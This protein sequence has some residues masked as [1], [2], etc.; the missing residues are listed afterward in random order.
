MIFLLQFEQFCINLTNKKLQQYFN[1]VC[2]WRSVPFPSLLQSPRE[3]GGGE[4]RR[5]RRRRHRWPAL[6]QPNSTSPTKTHTAWRK[7]E[8]SVD[9]TITHRRAHQC[10][11]LWWPNWLSAVKTTGLCS[12]LVRNFALLNKW[13]ASAKFQSSLCLMFCAFSS[14][15]EFSFVTCFP[16]FCLLPCKF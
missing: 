5:W 6:L 11:L 8:G 2:V 15:F 16:S 1:Q 7:K 10:Y 9:Q 13:E 12:V 4:R 14:L 3:R